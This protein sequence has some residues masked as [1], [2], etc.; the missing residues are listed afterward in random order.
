ML[1]AIRH[2]FQAAA[3]LCLFVLLQGAVALAD[4]NTINGLRVGFTDDATRIV[5]E[6]A[7]KTEVRLF[8]LTD[9]WRLVVDMPPAS[10]RAVGPD[11]AMLGASGPLSVSPLR[12]FRYGVPDPSTSRLVLEM[13]TPAIP[14]A[15]FRLPK[16]APAIGER[17][18]IDL[19]PRSDTVFRV[20]AQAL[21][22][23]QQ[24]PMVL[25]QRPD[26]PCIFS[27][28]A[29]ND[30]CKPVVPTEETAGML[31]PIPKPAAPALVAESRAPRWVV[32]IDAGHGGKDPGA[33]GVSGTKEKTVTLESA[34]LLAR[35]LEETGQVKP[36]LSRRDDVYHSLRKRISLAR[37]ASADLFISLHADAAR[38]SKAR[39]FSVFT[40]S[41]RAS[42]AEAA[43][44]AAQENKADLIGGADLE[45]ADP[46]IS[47]ALL[48]MFQRESMNESSVLADYIL[49]H[50]G[51]LA[52][53]Q[54]GHRFAGF[55]VLKSPDLPSVLVEMGFLTNRQDERNLN[56]ASWRLGLV[57]RLRDAIMDYLETR[58]KQ[59]D[60]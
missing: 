34:L 46:V 3:C 18:V 24:V 6:T 35:L 48:G 10:W 20:A 22:N 16:Q 28:Q 1:A 54:R 39:G 14:V 7:E 11:G 27:G 57:S 21:L 12:R 58:W 55:A 31:L 43:R 56:D 51:P 42:D 40:L 15:V 60:S 19:V 36:V 26:G 13:A 50:A 52:A 17:L 45:T 49:R 23:G 5:L 44:L 29:E 30:S 38:N 32:F 41:D 53:Q 47:E 2:V 37:A 4:E 59:K 33:I 8:L 25:Q 9:P